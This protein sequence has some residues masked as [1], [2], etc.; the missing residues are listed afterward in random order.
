MW[1]LWLPLLTS[2]YSK[3]FE[4]TEFSEIFVVGGHF[5]GDRLRLWPSLPR[6]FLPRPPKF[7]HQRITFWTPDSLARWPQRGAGLKKKESRWSFVGRAC[8][9][10][11]TF[12]KYQKGNTKQADKMDQFSICSNT[13]KGQR[14][15]FFNSISLFKLNLIVTTILG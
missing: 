15:F 2:L 11:Y 1:F 10:P 6:R 7:S 4:K 9:K 8:F 13:Q 12:I 14:C 5:G 3:Q